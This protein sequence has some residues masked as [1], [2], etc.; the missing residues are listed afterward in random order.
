MVRTVLPR[1]STPACESLAD[2]VLDPEITDFCLRLQI[3]PVSREFHN[4]DDSDS[5]V[6][7]HS[8]DIKEESELKRFTQALQEAQIA[9][10]KREKDNK[11]KRGRYSKQSKKTLKRRKKLRIDLA[12]KGFLPVDEYM[13]RKGIPEKSNK[14]T[15]ESSTITLQEA[16]EDSDE[17]NGPDRDTCT[18]SSVNSASESEME[19]E[20]SLPGNLNNVQFRL[21]HLACMESEESSEDQDDTSK[22]LEDLQ[23]K[24]TLLR[25]EVSESQAISGSTLKLLGDHP[26][27]WEACMQ[28]TN[29]EKRGNLDVIIRARVAVMVGLLNIYTDDRMG[30]SW[31]SASEIVAK[32]QGR[33]KNHTRHIR[34][35]VLGFL[36]WRD[37]PLHQLNQK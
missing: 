14:P 36:K 27:L 31:K 35:W 8:S 17:E 22:N 30:H 13:R 11:N 29:E 19:S 20:E 10:L 2:C 18:Y 16:S 12:S 28:L 6:S 24:A 7:N 3:T 15:L 23:R 4:E 9:A 21:R 34:E 5:S 37:L 1:E 33:G 25:Q 26:K 32:M